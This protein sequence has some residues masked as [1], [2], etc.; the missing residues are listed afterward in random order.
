MTI[1]FIEDPNKL[2]DKRER[3]RIENRSAVFKM[4]NMD[5]DTYWVNP[6]FFRTLTTYT[7]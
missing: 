5:K 7:D 3:E 1:T 6:D 4:D 2:I